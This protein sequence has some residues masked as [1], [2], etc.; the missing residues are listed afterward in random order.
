MGGRLRVTAFGG[1]TKRAVGG[2]MKRTTPKKF[3]NLKRSE[4]H[5]VTAVPVVAGSGELHVHH[6]CAAAPKGAFRWHKHAGFIV[7][8]AHVEVVGVGDSLHQ[9]LISILMI[10]EH[11]CRRKESS[12]CV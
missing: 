10:F 7:K 9:V 12:G 4:R 5:A 8:D 6:H 11:L 2:T 3:L 1:T